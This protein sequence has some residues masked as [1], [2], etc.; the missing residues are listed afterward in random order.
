[1]GLRNC[2][3][4]KPEDFYEN[5][6]LKNFNFQIINK[7]K[8]NFD[9]SFKY[10]SEKIINYDFAESNKINRF[11]IRYKKRILIHTE[12]QQN[13]IHIF[14]YYLGDLVFNLISLR[15]NEMFRVLKVKF[16]DE[17]KSNA[18]AL[19]LENKQNNK[20]SILIIMISKSKFA[21]RIDLGLKKSQNNNLNN[22]NSSNHTYSNFEK[23]S[24]GECSESFVK[25]RSNDEKTEKQYVKKTLTSMGYTNNMNEFHSQSSI[26]SEKY[27]HNKNVKN[28]NNNNNP[29]EDKNLKVDK[30]HENLKDFIDQDMYTKKES[31]YNIKNNYNANSNTN[32]F[33]SP[34]NNQQNRD[35]EKCSNE[36]DKMYKNII[37]RRNNSETNLD[38]LEKTLKNREIIILEEIINSSFDSEEDERNKNFICF[39]SNNNNPYND[40]FLDLYERERYIIKNNHFDNESY[41]HYNEIKKFK[42]INNNLNIKNKN[43]NFLV[44]ENYVLEPSQSSKKIPQ[45]QKYF[46]KIDKKDL[47]NKFRD[48]IMT[49]YGIY[50]IELSILINDN[51][52]SAS[53]IEI[54]EN[55]IFIYISNNSNNLNF[56]KTYYI[57]KNLRSYRFISNIQLENYDPIVDNLFIISPVNSIILQGLNVVIL[58]NTKEVAKINLFEFFK[59]KFNSNE[60][61]IISILNENKREI[62]TYNVSILDDNYNIYYDSGILLNSKNVFYKSYNFKASSLNYNN[63]KTNLNNDKNSSS[64]NNNEKGFFASLFNRS[65]GVNNEDQKEIKKNNLKIEENN[66]L[67][68]LEILKFTN[69]FY[70]TNSLKENE[71]IM[72]KLIE[73]GTDVNFEEEHE[74]IKIDLEIEE[75]DKYVMGLE[76]ECFSP[77]NEQLN[78]KIS[79]NI[80]NENIFQKSNLNKESNRNSNFEI[81][82]VVNK[83][84]IKSESNIEIGNNLERKIITEN[85]LNEIFEKNNANGEEILNIKKII[86]SQNNLF[87]LYIT[88]LCRINNTGNFDNNQFI[89]SIKIPFWINFEFQ[90]SNSKSNFEIRHDNFIKNVDLDILDSDCYQKNKI[91]NYSNR[92]NSYHEKKKFI[93]ENSNKMRILEKDFPLICNIGFGP[94]IN[95]PLLTG[96]LNGMITIWEIMDLSIKMKITLND[97]NFPICNIISES[98]GVS[99]FN[100]NDCLVCFDIIDKKKELFYFEK[101]NEGL[102]KI[103]KKN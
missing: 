26:I 94:Y 1:M 65:I 11:K 86:K 96:H 97:I 31:K 66:F 80:L 21:S 52:F 77:N 67:L 87:Q 72:H 37:K 90:N 24:K 18:F 49:K 29:N 43:D 53:K 28:D 91:K 12:S 42:R 54:K 64:D 35:K 8:I 82:D 2:C 89:S 25:K 30:A 62:D 23:R 55:F 14:S 4:C 20:L 5:S 100:T 63:N 9:I 85:I 59:K 99:F 32:T 17:L 73:M 13:N 83:A 16:L 51:N 3:Y 95:G 48:V 75:T 93:L 44:E 41:N 102:Q 71:L 46:M 81:S 33:Y 7:D 38:K 6:K 69:I 98:N 19:C 22:D 34:L 78:K 57:E 15:I 92:N 39:D 61:E 70:K 36:T 47:Y 58:E 60:N 10:S 68:K 103:I 56:I 50:N 84:E 88:G 79:D 45:Y 101:N 27:F 74:K 76:K 40:S